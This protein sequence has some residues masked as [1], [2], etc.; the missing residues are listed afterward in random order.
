MKSFKKQR[1][2]FAA[3]IF[4]LAA[5]SGFSDSVKD[6]RKDIEVGDIL[7]DPIGAVIDLKIIESVKTG[8]IG[9]YVGDV[10]YGGIIWPNQVIEA[11]LVGGGVY[12]IGIEVWDY[13]TTKEAWILRPKAPSEL[14]RKAVE[15]TESQI[16][17]G[18]TKLNFFSRNPSPNNER[19]YCSELIWAAYFQ[20]GKGI[21]LA[22]V[23]IEEVGGIINSAVS[24]LDI[25]VDDDVYSVS[26]HGD[27]DVIPEDAFRVY[28]ANLGTRY[29]SLKEAIEE[30]YLREG[31]IILIEPGGYLGG[32][33][34]EEKGVVLRAV[35]FDK[36]RRVAKTVIRSVKSVLQTLADLVS[37]EDRPTV[38]TILSS[39]VVLEG[40]TITG[41][42]G[43]EEVGGIKITEGADNCRISNCILFNNPYGVG[44]V[45]SSHHVIRDNSFLFNDYGI[46]FVR[47]Y[48]GE[49]FKNRIEGSF[50]K[51]FV[52]G[53]NEEA[54]ASTAAVE[55]IPG[56][57]VLL[58]PYRDL[59]DKIL[60]PQTVSDYYR[61]SL[62]VLEVFRKDKNLKKEAREL[63]SFW[64]PKIK[65]FFSENKDFEIRREE[66]ERTAEFLEKLSGGLENSETK[67]F[68]ENLLKEAE[69]SGGKKF[70]EAVKNS[71]FFEEKKS[72]TKAKTENSK[73]PT[74][75]YLNDF[76]NNKEWSVGNYPEGLFYWFSPAEINY[77]FN[78]KNFFGFLGNYWG[79][80]AMSFLDKDGNG[81]GDSAY[82][83]DLYPLMEGEDCYGK[84]KAEKTEVS[85][86]ILY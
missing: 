27:Y 43:S 66:A 79:E 83:N 57:D 63:I 24:P 70:S 30:K 16:G 44:A 59:R 80:P 14:K 71:S 56:S 73:K 45:D 41:A 47:S 13:P 28:N 64:S 85:D 39:D 86:W 7:Y 34:V 75:V 62:P 40:L 4:I 67:I 38:I 84:K 10:E 53:E 82:G 65:L 81:I 18:Y 60:K 35:D 54:C 19:W 46:G 50:K 23:N 61:F 76:L 31:D 22:S 69:I 33:K 72:S 12:M 1:A 17:K 6:W 58:S 49:V 11:T 20:E 42:W 8:H 77:C 15:F 25:F 48:G 74:F 2:F 51:G 21:D 3:A 37:F 78:N 68:V 5:A 9:I 29:F 52:A 26:Y 55:E 32:G 36:E